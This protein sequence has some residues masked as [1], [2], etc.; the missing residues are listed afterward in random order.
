M[1]DW[2]AAL[3][4][5]FFAVIAGGAF[6]MMWGNIRNT[7]WDKPVKSH[8]EAPESGEEVLY[9]NFSREQLEELYQK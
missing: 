4:F 8:P 3:Y 1:N 9:A 7:N 2:Y 5:L 6:A